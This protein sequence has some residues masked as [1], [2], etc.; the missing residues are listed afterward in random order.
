MRTMEIVS[1]LRG[2]G[3]SR[4]RG[5]A[6]AGSRG[7]EVAGLLRGDVLGRE[8]ETSRPRNPETPQPHP[9]YPSP[10]SRK[11]LFEKVSMEQIIGVVR[12]ESVEAAESVAEA[13][14]RN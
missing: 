4:L 1:L 6:V 13:Y 2:R 7:C 5:L 9:R 11:E 8:R 3:V 14:A 10:M 12:E